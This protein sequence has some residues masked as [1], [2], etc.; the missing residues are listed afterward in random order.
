MMFKQILIFLFAYLFGSQVFSQLTTNTAL[1]PTQLVENVLV[2]QGIEVFNVKYT[3]ASKAIGEFNA[4]ASNVG[5]NEGLILSTGNVLDNIVSGRKNGPVGPNNK[6]D[7]TTKWLT[8]GDPSLTSI[9]GNVTNDA[10]V[11]EFDFI[12]QGDTIRF[13]YVFA[14]EEYIEYVGDLKYNDVFAFFISGPGFLTPKNIAVLPGTNTPVSINNVNN[15]TNNSFYINNGDGSNGPQSTDPTVVNFDGL[16]VKLTAIAK[17]TPCQVYHLKIALADVHDCAYDS[18]VF[19]QSGSLN[20]NPAFSFIN[21]NSFNPL[22]EDTIILEGCSNGKLKFKRYDKLWTSYVLNF[23]VLGTAESGVDYAL[24]ANKVNFP[25][26]IDEVTININSIADNLNEETESVILRFP[27]PFICISDSVDII[28]S[29]LDRTPLVTKTIFGDITCPGDEFE[30]KAIVSGGV[31]GYSFS[32]SDGNLNSINKVSPVVTEKYLYTVTDTCGR[33]KFDSAIITVPNFQPLTVDLPNDTTI[34]CPGVELGITAKVFGGGGIYNYLWD[35]GGNSNSIKDSIF[36]NETYWVIVSDNCGNS[37]SD[38]ISVDLNYVNFSVT[39]FSDTTVCSGD[40]AI[41]F[42]KAT[43]GIKPYSYVWETGDLTS[44]A[45]YNGL[46]SKFVLVSVMDSCG[47]IPSKDS[48][49]VTIQKP[50]ANFDI[51]APISEILEIIYFKSSSIGSILN[52]DWDFGNGS[53]SI[54][55]D[56]QTNYIIDSLYAIKLIVEDDL[57]CKDSIV[58]QIEISPPLYYYLPNSF[59][60]NGDGVNEKFVGKGL[61]I[62]K[63]E[64][65]IFDRW[66]IEVFSSTDYNINWEG[67]YKS[68]KHV[69]TG[70]YVYKV[71]IKGDSGK[72]FEKIGKVTLIR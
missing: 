12:P 45:N 40:T 2:G 27:S 37:K 65:L 16:T 36:K 49:F 60:P 48:V 69:P 66:G 20:S 5:I 21:D 54:L 8:P 42:S 44:E 56:D 18:G 1:T 13:N 14:S 53:V 38:T 30:M 26:N 19:L 9:V 32:W 71:F 59:T 4:A 10:V 46:T 39:A 68:G 43:G 70:V 3:G 28:Y 33:S 63:F 17:V 34:Y 22:K 35:S 23:R 55:E 25:P 11:L 51:I 62:D 6:G 7:A 67:R 52:Y 29:I 24:S 50:T 15:V 57:G 72:Q 58:K 64:I 41:L 31:P 61:G 47:I